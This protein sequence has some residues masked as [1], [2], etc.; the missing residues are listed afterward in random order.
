MFCLKD[1]PLGHTVG[2]EYSRPR[3]M[4]KCWFRSQSGLDVLKSLALYTHHH[5]FYTSR[6][7]LDKLD[8]HHCSTPRKRMQ[9]GAINVYCNL[10]L[11]NYYNSKKLCYCRGTARRAMLVNSCYV[12]CF[13]FFIGVRKV[14]NSRRDDRSRSRALAMVQFDGPDTIS[15]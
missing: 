6:N 1:R 7:N 12:L 4:P 2:W 11:C 15:Y 3:P 13:M 9:Y 8:T 5:I 14:S 10:K